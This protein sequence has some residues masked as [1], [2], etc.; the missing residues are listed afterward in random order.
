[1]SSLLKYVTVIVGFSPLASY[2]FTERSAF[3]V[4]CICFIELKW[5]YQTDAFWMFV[6]SVCSL[7]FEENMQFLVTCLKILYCL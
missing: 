2:F 3:I 4:M 1:M 6:L 7:Y 5:S